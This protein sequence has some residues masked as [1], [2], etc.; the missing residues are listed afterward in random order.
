M[1]L[2]VAGSG[3]VRFIDLTSSKVLEPLTAER[4]LN[5]TH[6]AFS[7]GGSLLAVGGSKGSLSLWHWPSRRRL[8]VLSGHRG[9]VNSIDFSA[10]DSVLASADTEGLVKLWSVAERQGTT[11]LPCARARPRGHRR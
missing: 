6:V 2:A 7:H 1:I 11:D 3:S 10:D 9:G 5:A 4:G 8:A